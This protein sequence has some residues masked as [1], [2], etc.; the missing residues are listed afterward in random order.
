[1][2][3]VIYIFLALFLVSCGSDY[4]SVSS[5]DASNDLNISAAGTSGT[6]M[7]AQGILSN[8]E[9]GDY[10]EGE[11][12]VKFRSGVMQ[13]SS[14]S[15]HQAAGASV[16]KRF[17]VVQGLEHVRLPEG[18]SVSDAITQYMSEPDVEYA[19]PNYIRRISSMN[20]PNDEY[21]GNQYALHNTGTY[22]GGFDDADIDAPEAWV[23]STGS[24][25]I[26][27]AILDTGIDYDHSDLAGNIYTNPLE[28]PTNL[29]DDDGNGLVDDWRGWNFFSNTN[30]PMDDNGHGTHVAGT[31]GA[32][33]NNGAGVSG[34]MQSV[35]LMALKVCDADGSCTSSAL[36]SGI[37]YAVSKGA[38][39]MNASL[40]GFPFSMSE[41]NTL[42][43]ARNSGVLLV[44]AAGNGS[45]DGVGDDNDINPH[46][47]SGYDLDNVIA[48]AATDQNDRRV[49]FSNY[50]PNSVDV[51]APGVYIFS[52]VPNWWSSFAG[53]G[54]LDFF[55]GTSMASP[56]VAGLAGLLYSYYD[57]VQDTGFTYSQTRDTIFR[58]VDPLETLDGWIKTGGRI[59]AYKAITSIKKPTGL[60]AVL[61]GAFPLPGAE[62]S[63]A[64]SNTDVTLT[65][66]D[67]ATGEDGYQVE[68]RIYDTGS[69]ETIT[70]L[71]PDHTTYTD[72]DVSSSTTY[73]YRVRAFNNI[74][75]SFYSNWEIASTG[76][77]G[78]GGCSIIAGHGSSTVDV[79]ILLIPAAAVIMAVYRRRRRG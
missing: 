46:Y 43:A 62:N 23:T 35:Q 33:G 22:A 11:L 63:V 54:V 59:N 10:L 57:G 12:L 21:F 20:I 48:V 42:Q 41:F 75:N 39:V 19:E 67:N 25:N 28:N 32:V 26:K 45:M 16:S 17:P 70:F 36:I 49:P 29:I 50:G 3:K 6:V 13:A 71:G 77:D 30:N 31:V 69:F 64:S 8:M 34:V 56:H 24:N 53:F 44:A 1:M 79:I 47:P 40:G 18:L 37:N 51:G 55:A 72:S 5:K 60:V 58:Y 68:R 76:R 9:K 73:Q 65:W 66:T 14:L 2:K 74:A 27:V 15:V 4:T 78:G 7:S 52:T 38:N 61:G